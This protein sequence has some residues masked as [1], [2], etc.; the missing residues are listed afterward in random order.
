MHS[1]NYHEY[2]LSQQK[3][4]FIAKVETHN[5]P[6]AISPFAGAATGVG[7]ELRDEG[8]T[9]V[10]GT[11]VMGLA[12]FNVSHLL[13]DNLPESWEQ[14]IGKPATICSAQRIM[15]EGPIGAA[16]YNNEFGRA[17]TLGYFRVLL[18]RHRDQW[19]GY[20]KPIMLVGGIGHIQARHVHKSA[21]KAGHGLFVLGGPALLIGLGGG[22]ASSRLQHEAT[23]ALDFASVQRDN[24][25]MQR[26]CQ[27]VLASCSSAAHNPITFIHD[28]GAGGLSNALPELLADNNLGGIINIDAIPRA[29]ESLSLMELWCNEAQERY[30]LS[31]APAHEELFL[32]ICQRERCPV[33]RVGFTTAD[34]Q[35][36]FQSA[37]KDIVTTP[38]NTLFGYTGNEPIQMQAICRHNNHEPVLAD[39]NSLAIKVLRHPSVASKQFLITIADRTIGGQIVCEQMVGAYQTPINNAAVCRADWQSDQGQAMAIGERPALALIDVAA[40]MRMTLAEVITNF[41][42]CDIEKLSDIKL[43]ANWM[44]AIGVDEENTPLY[45][46][47]TAVTAACKELNITIAVGKDSLAMKSQWKKNKTLHQVTSPLTLVLSGFVQI[48]NIYKCVQPVITAGLP[49]LLLHFGQQRLGGSIA[50]QCQNALGN[51][52]PDIQALQIKQLFAVCKFARPFTLA[53]HDRSDGGVWA[54]LC[55]MAFAARLGITISCAGD[56]CRFLLN[57]EVGVVIQIQADKQAA[58]QKFAVAQNVSVTQLGLPTTAHA[59]IV[60]RAD[61]EEHVFDAGELFADWRAVSQ[62]MVSKRDDADI[63]KQEQQQLNNWQQAL[64]IQHVGYS[65]AAIQNKIHSTSSKPRVAILREQGTNGHREMALAF[66]QA[67]CIAVDVHMTDLQSGRQTLDAFQGLV[68]CGGF[69]YGDVLGA[70]RGWAA[71]ILHDV[72]LREM[73]KSFFHRPTTLT[74]G[75]CNGCQ[76]LAQLRSCIPGAGHFPV[77]KRNASQQYEGRTANVRIAHSPSIL[78][79]DMQDTILPVPVA[80][81]EGR[82]TVAIPNAVTSMVWADHNSKQT[83]LYPYNPNGSIHGVAGLCSEDGRT[84]IMMPHPERMFLASQQTWLAPQQRQEFDKKFAPWL[85]M[86][87]NAKHWLQQR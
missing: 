4:H 72:Q 61:D 27:Q 16:N 13:L 20:H 34:Q 56:V 74:L 53:C 5:H 57:E 69:S 75:V 37:A 50:L 60:V 6:T 63:A 73:F 39:F 28:V 26:R 80:H 11:P 8:A 83:Q 18:S 49:L 78:L 31:M 86:F 2:V 54:T 70:G 51:T 44:A 9:G 14:D 77:F 24:P 7:G 3:A 87:A 17:N 10:G 42:G 36:R 15:L 79:Q 66:I 68:A 84:T 1:N 65:A 67:G 48:A 59:N 55:E 43:S 71:S 47:V 85:M 62:A 81:G 82:I 52:P 35:I 76:M 45:E 33:A 21:V 22:S 29:D 25:E 12:G 46:G 64:V 19:Y 58:L 32:H 38:L 23:A 30:V 41:S 40:A